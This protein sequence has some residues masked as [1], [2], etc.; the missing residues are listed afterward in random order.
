MKSTVTVQVDTDTLLKM[1]RR[2]NDGG[3][4]PDMSEAVNAAIEFWLYSASGL[5]TSLLTE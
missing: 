1:I 5:K 4:S 2:L 3:K